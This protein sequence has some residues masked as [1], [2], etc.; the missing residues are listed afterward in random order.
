MTADV[1]QVKGNQLILQVHVQPR[2]SKNAWGRLLKDGENEWIQ[3]KITSPP[4]DG[5]ANKACIQIIAKEFKTA[6]SNVRILQGEKSRYKV[7]QIRD[8]NEDKLRE[9]LKSKLP[10]DIN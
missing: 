6:K 7:F 8:Y 2:S 4:V 5:A 10:V 9:F 3:L 1:I